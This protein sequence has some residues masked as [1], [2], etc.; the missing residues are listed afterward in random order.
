MQYSAHFRFTQSGEVCLQ[1]VAEHCRNT[2]QNAAACLR[3]IGME[4]VGYL[5]GLLHDMG[6]MTAAFQAYLEDG[7]SPHPSMR[8]GSV[9]HTY[10][11]AKFFLRHFHAGT[12]CT[13]ITAEIL[14]YAAGAHHGLFDCLD[15]EQRNGFQ[16]R[17][18]WN[19]GQ[20]T[21]AEQAFLLQCAPM[22][23]LAGLFA[24]ADEQLQ[25]L[26][27]WL[28]GLRGGEKDKEGRYFYCGMMARLVL[29]AVIDGDRRDSAA[30]A[31]GEPPYRAKEF[32][33]RELLEH[34]ER[35][36]AAFP[37]ETAIDRARGE[38]S[39][40]CRQAAERPCGIYR[41]S[42]PT[43][44]GKTLASL[45][46][47]LA[48]AEKNGSRR[49]IFTAPL[50]GII[51][52]NADVL[53]EYIGD[54]ELV[55]EH[56]SDLVQEKE[57][58]DKLGQREL[59]TENWDAPVIITTLV[60]LLNT[61]F[62][63]RASC[64]RRMQALCNSVIVIDEVQ[65][66]P[67]RMLSLFNM[68][69]NFLVKVCR[70]SVVLCS[71]T[72][73]CLEAARRPICVC[74][75]ELVPH[76]PALWAPFCRTQLVDAGK[77]TFEE[78]P[79]FVLRVLEKTDS[80]LIVC[81][82]KAEARRLYHALKQRGLQCCHLSAAM[83]RAHR[84]DVLEQL[85][86]ALQGSTCG[87]PKAVCVSTQVIEA[88]IDISFASVIRLAAGMDNVVQ[89]AGRCNRNGES[90]ELAPVYL[91]RREDEDLRRLKDIGDA[92]EATLQLLSDFRREP[93]RFQN[94]LASDPAIAQYYR[95]LYA[96]MKEDGQ[97]LPPVFDLLAAN[98]G[99]QAKLNDQKT[100]KGY[101]L[102]Q[103][104]REAGERFE[105]FSEDT[106]AV[107]VPYG[108]GKDL[109]AGLGSREAPRDLQKQREL[110]R[111]LKP[112][113]VSL[114]RWEKEN[115]AAQGALYE[116]WDGAVAVLAPEYYDEEGVGAVL[117]P[118]HSIFWEE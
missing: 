62:D 104:F 109:I 11:G 68:A 107:A 9:I 111:E 3:G 85:K 118:I 75:E 66:V 100:V 93:A 48:H 45:R 76:D 73:P 47:A 24:R 36:L 8:R 78:L 55:L 44:S 59:M 43:G 114:Y 30:F 84:K 86:R 51:D 56:H 97:D 1:S 106:V 21:E 52:Q 65:S 27:T 58:K 79:S 95:Y 7:M 38:I 87:G 19:E 20:Y 42:V 22:E 57:E 18:D 32:S 108:K 80:L 96:N 69:V 37:Q 82:K 28:K 101:F 26:Y 90:A 61:L 94:D 12:G 13:Q 2:G 17:E 91:V 50:L 60:Q 70:A 53:R 98:F 64:I 4:D 116:Y 115:L 102:R 117:K 99:M 83:C 103:A 77:F 112:Y 6:K 63:G 105:V 5:A 31:K 49:L 33:W 46:F 15:A 54:E 23:E 92:R 67:V 110:L 34:A 25:P 89:A 35:K 16:I 29:S 40:R 14:A 72:Q 74:A 113:T 39:M 88:G 71:A 41:L 10:H 81:N